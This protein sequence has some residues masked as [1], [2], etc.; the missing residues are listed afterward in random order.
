MK[1]E[2]NQQDLSSCDNN[3]S[4]VFVSGFADRFH[5]R[6]LARAFRTVFAA[7]F[8]LLTKTEKSVSFMCLILISER[9]PNFFLMSALP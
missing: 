5:V 9:K 1:N 7:S 8:C 2:K 4:R 3:V 6:P